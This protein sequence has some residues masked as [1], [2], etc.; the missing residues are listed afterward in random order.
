M[1]KNTSN[2]TTAQPT[3]T[4]LY[5]VKYIEDGQIKEAVAFW[6]TDYQWYGF[7]NPNKGVRKHFICR[8]DKIAGSGLEAPY[9][10]DCEPWINLYT[11]IFD[12]VYSDLYEHGFN[13]LDALKTLKEYD[14]ELA[15]FLRNR[16]SD[17]WKSYTQPVPPAQR[18]NKSR[19]SWHVEKNEL[20]SVTLWLCVG[21]YSG[22]KN[23]KYLGAFL[24]YEEAAERAKAGNDYVA[25]LA[26]QFEEADT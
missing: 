8:G 13:A 16:N 14:V 2:W 12:R 24:T 20:E 22:G 9:S 18:R 26:K 10:A 17:M 1:E 15:A 4:G 25:E 6:G 3:E 23:S 11:A 7:F 21:G 19:Q 5:P